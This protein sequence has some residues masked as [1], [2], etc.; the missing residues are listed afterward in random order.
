MTVHGVVP[1]LVTVTK[2]VIVPAAPWPWP[3]D[4][5][6]WL[7]AVEPAVVDV[8]AGADDRVEREERL[9]A[10]AAQRELGQAHRAGRE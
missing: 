4:A 3:G 5:V 2:P 9:L 10:A 7:Q 8:V 6:T 1:A